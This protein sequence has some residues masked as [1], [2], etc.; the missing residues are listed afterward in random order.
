MYH[1]VSGETLVAYDLCTMER[2]ACTSLTHRPTRLV[3]TSDGSKAFHINKHENRVY[4]LSLQEGVIQMAFKIP[5]E[6]HFANGDKVW[7]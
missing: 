1:N 3:F 4:G 7:A 2:T 5:V 6:E